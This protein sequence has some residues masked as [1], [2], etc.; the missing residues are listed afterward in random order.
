MNPI[1][2]QKD[3]VTHLIRWKLLEYTSKPKAKLIVALAKLSFG[4]HSIF[5]FAVLLTLQFLTN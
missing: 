3:Q 1:N 5:N 4:K 2:T